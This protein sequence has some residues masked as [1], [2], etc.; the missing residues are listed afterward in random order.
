MNTPLIREYSGKQAK[1]K[2]E[3]RRLPG[4]K[5]TEKELLALSK[6]QL[7]KQESFD[8]FRISWDY[9]KIKE[10]INDRDVTL[11]MPKYHSEGP[12]VIFVP[13]TGVLLFELYAD[14]YYEGTLHIDQSSKAD[15][16]WLTAHPTEWLGKE[17]LKALG[18]WTRKFVRE[19]YPSFLKKEGLRVT[20]SCTRE[21]EV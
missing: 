8:I 12:K 15:A 2:G 6:E 21:V 10:I 9:R 14:T 3:E 18:D 4:Q 5:Y 11:T 17:Q 19:S 20:I 1:V 7:K 13:D 16:V